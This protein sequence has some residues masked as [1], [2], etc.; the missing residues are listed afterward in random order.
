MLSASESKWFFFKNSTIW[1]Y[2]PSFKT[3]EFSAKLT[4]KSPIK[5]LLPVRFQVHHGPGAK[6]QPGS[7]SPRIRSRSMPF[8]ALCACVERLVVGS[9]RLRSGSHHVNIFVTLHLPPCWRRLAHSDGHRHFEVFL[10]L[11]RSSW[12]FWL[13]VWVFFT[14]ET[15]FFTP[16]IVCLLEFFNK[17]KIFKNSLKKMLFT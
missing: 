4:M 8:I 5:V 6:E 13:W 14:S 17:N 11:F 7:G 16:K 1:W 15:V 2:L 10:S 9:R 3:F 12:T